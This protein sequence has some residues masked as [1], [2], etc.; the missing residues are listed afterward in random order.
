MP[1]GYGSQADY[2][3]WVRDD[4]NSR[5]KTIENALRKA[6]SDFIEKREV[7]VIVFSSMTAFDLAEAIIDHPLILKPLLVASNIAAR[8]I[9]RD[10]SIKNVDTYKPRLSADQAKV[11]AGYIKPFLPPYLEIPTFS[12]IDRVAFI[13]NEIRKRKGRWEKRVL[14]ALNLFGSSQ[15][16]K[17]IF[18]AAGEQFE[19]DAA[20]P[21]S[22]DIKVGIDIKRIEAR[23]D[24]HKRCDEIVS[25]ATKLKS[26]FPDSKFGAIVYYP[27]I[28]EHVNV[29]NRLRSENIE[30]VVFASEA[31]ESIENAVKML[32]PTLGVLRND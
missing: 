4:A 18:T 1:D 22:G 28:E 3:D 21:R 11:I 5:Q 14:K 25:K 2:M 10:L 13:D 31:K 20:S 9:E 19:L 15:F 6:F 24:I 12:Q 30:G 16:H 32:L 23:R 17:R 8:S 7:E 27:F 29:Q 26:T